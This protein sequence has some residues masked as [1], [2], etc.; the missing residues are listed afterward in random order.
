MTTALNKQE[1]QIIG[2][3]LLCFYLYFFNAY[4]F[5]V[6]YVQNSKI[7]AQFMLIFLTYGRTYARFSSPLIDYSVYA[8]SLRLCSTYACALGFVEMLDVCLMYFCV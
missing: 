5:G 1:A 7:C 2:P 8:C 3:D 6:A 4:F